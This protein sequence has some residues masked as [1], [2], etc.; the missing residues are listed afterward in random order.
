MVLG[1]LSLPSLAIA[2]AWTWMS[3]SALAEF[4]PEDIE[5]S[6]RWLGLELE[7]SGYRTLRFRGS[8][9]DT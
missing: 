5:Q 7:Q 1:I 8:V 9:R 2:G 4:T 6:T 3:E